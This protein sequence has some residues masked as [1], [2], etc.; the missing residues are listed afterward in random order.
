[1]VPAGRSALHSTRT[2][3]TPGMRPRPATSAVVKRVL[4][5]PP[6]VVYG[7][8]LDPG[9][10]REFMCPEPARATDIECEPW[11]GGRLRIVMVDGET[12][13]RV[14]GEYLELKSPRLLRFTWKTDHHGG[15]ES[16]VTVTLEPHGHAET[17]M[18]IDHALPPQLIGDHEKGWNQIAE[19]LA[20]RLRA[21]R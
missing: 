21:S 9:A 5:A 11:V 18:T 15:F 12:V 13:I 2:P 14:T 20:R 16:V 17:V 10:L 7:E 1:M 6:E 8:W 3:Q 19:L 4:P